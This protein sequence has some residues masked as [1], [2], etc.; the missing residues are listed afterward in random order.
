M[1]E[2]RSDTTERQRLERALESIADG[3]EGYG[4]VFNPVTGQVLAADEAAD[5]DRL[6]ATQMAREGF[7]FNGASPPRHGPMHALDCL[8]LNV[9]A[10]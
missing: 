1:N 10:A 2:R 8:P 9:Y 4:L 5:E 7:F 6:P 3:K